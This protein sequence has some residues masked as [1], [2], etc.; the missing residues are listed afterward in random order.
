MCLHAGGVSG[1]IQRARRRFLILRVRRAAAKVLNNCKVCARYRAKPEQEVVP[2]LPKF[3]ID[4]A[5]PFAVTGVDA[6]GP[7]SVKDDRGKI[8]KAWV[9]LFACPLTRAIRLELVRDL[10]TY[11]FLL[12]FRRFFNRNA[13][14]TKLVSDN[15]TAFRR[16]AKEINFLFKVREHQEI[17]QLLANCRIAWYFNVARA[18]WRFS[19]YERIFRMLKEPLRKILGRNILPAVEFATL[20]TDFEKII[21][22]R[23]I[24][25]V[26][27]DP[28]EPM[29][30][31][32]S[33]LLGGYQVQPRL[34]DA[35]EIGGALKGMEP[36]IFT[37]R[38]KAQQDILNA[39]WNRFRREYLQHLRS[40]HAV[41]QNCIL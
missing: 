39:F 21:N 10:P 13:T 26:S 35:K 2:P 11:E 28:N 15:A 23:P 25:A 36:A 7:F 5:P 34:P 6:A 22:G 3:R 16:A 17:Q 19:F 31:R 20:L 32:P 9:M 41:E 24:T 40:V 1:I 14:V 4:K 18:P 38:W 8:E 27:T 33:D 12:A 29:P 30:L 37:Q